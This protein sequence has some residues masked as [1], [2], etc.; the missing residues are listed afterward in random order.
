MLPFSYAAR[1]L[2]RSK[3]RLLQTI[4]GSALVVLLVMA[5][6]AIN[7]G[8]NRLLS[9]SGSPNNVILLGTGSEESVQRSEVPEKA[10][11]IASASIPGVTE[12]LGVRAVSPEIHYMNYLMLD[13]GGNGRRSCGA[14]RPRRCGCIP[15]SDSRMAP[16]PRLARSWWAAS[17]GGRSGFPRTP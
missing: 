2:F 13:D 16:S 8:M 1:N 9:A 5:A 11:G 14:S 17:R 4:G 12:S 3:S 7:Q 6:V 10:A 15:K